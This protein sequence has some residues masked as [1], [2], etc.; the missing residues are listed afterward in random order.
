MDFGKNSA[1]KDNGTKKIVDRKAI[2]LSFSRKLYRLKQMTML[3]VEK[4]PCTI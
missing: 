3:P 4:E 2:I 1:E